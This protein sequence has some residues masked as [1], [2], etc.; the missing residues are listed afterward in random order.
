MGKNDCCCGKYN[1]REGTKFI[2]IASSILS[3]L[4]IAG[5][6]WELMKLM[7][8]QSEIERLIGSLENLGNTLQQLGGEF[9]SNNNSRQTASDAFYQRKL[10]VG[11]G[12][13]IV[14]VSL[15]T[16]I[17]LFFAAKKNNRYIALPYMIWTIILQILYGIG[18]AGLIFLL[19]VGDWNNSENDII[20]TVVAPLVGI[21]ISFVLNT[22]W[23]IVVFN[24]Y[25]LHRDGQA[26][27]SIPMQTA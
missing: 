4:S 21:I 14:V 1:A 26:F 22:W 24:F 6:I 9:T 16:A 19:V 25:N 10:V 2:A 5:C 23:L 8:A 11:V 12:L 18:I 20:Q 15:L 3:A 13:G 27:D 17:A 7:R